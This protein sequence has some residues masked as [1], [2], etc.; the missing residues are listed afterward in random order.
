MKGDLAKSKPGVLRPAAKRDQSPGDAFIFPGRVDAEDVDIAQP[1][2]L[3]QY[4]LAAKAYDVIQK[5]L[6]MEGTW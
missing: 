5:A 2:E 1:G 4:R 3:A 6:A